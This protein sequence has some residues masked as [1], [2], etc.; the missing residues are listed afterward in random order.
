[1]GNTDSQS[2]SS[3][4]KMLLSALGLF[5]DKQTPQKHEFTGRDPMAE[6]LY[7]VDT[8]PDENGKGKASASIEG[9]SN[10]GR[11]KI[12]P[13]CKK[14]VDQVFNL[15]STDEILASL[16]RITTGTQTLVSRLVLLTVIAGLSC[17]NLRSLDLLSV[18]SFCRLLRLVHAGRVNGMPGD[19][20]QV[21]TSSIHQ[22]S[23]KALD[24][25]GDAIT[26][27]ITDEGASAADDLMQSCSRDLFAAAVCGAKL[28]ERWT[29]PANFSRDQSDVT[30]MSNPNFEV[31]QILVQI[32]AK[33]VTKL[34]GCSHGLV[35]V[36]DALAACLFSSKLQS[37]HRHWALEQLVKIL[38]VCSNVSTTSTADV[39]QGDQAASMIIHSICLVVIIYVAALM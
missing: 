24:C 16:D 35:S 3:Y 20:L 26:A 12:S 34:T 27:M 2:S 6:Q 4:Y 22:H 28:S 33:S 29:G 9:R 14:I 1:M 36:V 37:S 21:P 8:R 10:T 32:L 13:A 23:V 7:K 11:Y 18:Q 17:P 39:D 31:S 38:A 5:Q 19:T 15:K 30:I 25:L